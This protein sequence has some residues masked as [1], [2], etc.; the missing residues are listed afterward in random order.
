MFRDGRNLYDSRMT[1]AFVTRFAH[2]I[3]PLVCFNKVCDV[4]LNTLP[5]NARARDYMT[6]LN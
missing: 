1:K 4:T 3:A 2:A 5:N 6:S